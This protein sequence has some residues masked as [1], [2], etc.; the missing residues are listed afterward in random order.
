M[1]WGLVFTTFGLGIALIILSPLY[2]ALYSAIEKIKMKAHLDFFI[3]TS[4]IEQALEE[5]IE[6]DNFEQAINEI[7]KE[8]L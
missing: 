7:F 1:N 4:K 6:D 2:L 5:T 3:A 8:D